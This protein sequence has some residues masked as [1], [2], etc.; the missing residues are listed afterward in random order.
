MVSSKHREVLAPFTEERFNEIKARAEA[1]GYT[2]L[3]TWRQGLKHIRLS[4]IVLREET[5]QINQ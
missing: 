5:E 2:V 4:P 1:R 3:S